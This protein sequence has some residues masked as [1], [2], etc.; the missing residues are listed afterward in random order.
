MITSIKN[1]TKKQKNPQKTDRQNP[2]TYQMVK[3]KLYRQSHTQKHTHTLS[4]K[5]KKEK[6][7]YI[8]APKVHRLNSGMI[9]CL[10]RYS[11][12]AWYIKLIVEI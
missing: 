10:F 11:R 4:E 7:I 8:I 1:Y 3:A 6:N 5:E 12:G 9:S 2:R